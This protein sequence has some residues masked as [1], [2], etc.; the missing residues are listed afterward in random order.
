[1]NNIFI[2]TP[3]LIIKTLDKTDYV[4][5]RLQQKYPYLTEFFGGP[6]DEEKIK[7]IFNL[8]LNQQEQYG[9]S[10]GPVYL[11]KTGELIGR[12]GLVNLDFKPAFDVGLAC[13]LLQS[14]TRKGYAR[15]LCEALIEY[16]FTVL[17]TPRV[18]A[19]VDPEN[20]A[21]CQVEKLGMMFERENVYET[22]NKTVRFYVKNKP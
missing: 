20:V 11:K 2:E 21:A 1:M 9:F 16:A 17:K 3:R 4:A 7:E 14:H 19:T 10:V 22:L 5:Y 6:R 15:E 12:A 8:L 13:F 18:Y